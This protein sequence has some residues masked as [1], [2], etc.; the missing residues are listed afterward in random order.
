[1][2]GADQ[3]FCPPECRH[4]DT[5]SG[6]GACAPCTDGGGADLSA[7]HSTGKGASDGCTGG[8]RRAVFAPVDIGHE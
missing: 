7:A 4:V 5:H 2:A 3:S 8:H 6:G 1:M